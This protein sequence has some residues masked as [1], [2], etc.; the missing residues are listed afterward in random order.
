M[1]AL[2]SV[3]RHWRNKSVARN[4]TNYAVGPNTQKKRPKWWPIAVQAIYGHG[5]VREKKLYLRRQLERVTTKWAGKTV[6]PIKR[7]KT[8]QVGAR[9]LL[10]AMVHQFA[11]RAIHSRSVVSVWGVGPTGRSC[12]LVHVREVGPAHERRRYLR[13]VGCAGRGRAVLA[14]RGDESMLGA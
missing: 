7:A 9:G 3:P 2:G 13:R 8:V 14:F 4:T 11:A 1:Q 5:G 6:G 10:Q 12:H